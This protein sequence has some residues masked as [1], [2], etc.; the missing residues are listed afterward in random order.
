VIPDEALVSQYYE[1]RHQLDQLVADFR[2][3]ITHPTYS[4]PFLQPG[5]LVRVKYEKLDF[6]WGVIVNYQKRLPIRVTF[7][8]AAIIRPTSECFFILE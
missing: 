4:L 2:E 7:Q 8:I 3:V 1:Y 6:G 5:R